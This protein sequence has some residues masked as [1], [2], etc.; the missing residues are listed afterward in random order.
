LPNKESI[1]IDISKLNN[2]ISLTPNAV[3]LEPGITND[4]LNEVLKESN[5]F[6]PVVL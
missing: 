3:I 5:K 4:Q 2:I 6:F 1:L